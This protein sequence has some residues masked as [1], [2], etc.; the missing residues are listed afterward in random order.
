MEGP[1]LTTD[2]ELEVYRALR[3]S[4]SKYAYFL[5]AAA[6][7]AIALAVNQTHGSALAWSQVPLGLAVLCWGASFYCGCRHLA[8][9]SS[10]LYANAALLEI[11]AGDHP[12]VG[13]HPGMIAAASEGVLS[14]IEHN[15]NRGVRF[16]T[17]QFWLL[18]SGGVLYVVWHVLEMYLRTVAVHP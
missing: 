11:R 16:A 17:F 7:A 1:P 13:T 2:V 6:G 18:V 4:Q 8:Y 9:V 5:L 12:V 15:S 14:A 10:T 3:E